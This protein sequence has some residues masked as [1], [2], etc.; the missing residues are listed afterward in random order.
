MSKKIIV[1][2]LKEIIYTAIFIVLG[3]F[4]ILLLIFMFT[5]NNKTSSEKT[6]SYI[7]GIYSS[8]AIINDQPVNVEVLVDE[9]EIIS[10]KFDDL[11]PSVETLYPLLQ[12]SLED[13]S[14]QIN[15]TSNFEEFNFSSD[16]KY[17]SELLLDTIQDA[18]EKAKIEQ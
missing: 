17:T 6:M 2:Q 9:N 18:L 12:P 4:L 10:V 8:S 3:I 13:I 1:I 11:S 14:N 15:S 16:K 5:L 7:P